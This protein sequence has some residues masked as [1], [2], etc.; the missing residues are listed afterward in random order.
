MYHRQK[1]SL[2]PSAGWS[3]RRLSGNDRRGTST[4]FIASV[5]WLLSSI[6]LIYG[7]YSYCTNNQERV[8]LECT[9]TAC[10]IAKLWQGAIS[11]EQFQREQLLRAEL[12]RLDAEG[13]VVDVSG[14]RQ[15]ELKKLGYSYAVIYRPAV[16]ETPQEAAAE[17]ADAAAPE[18]GA[19]TAEPKP[20]DADANSAA[21]AGSRRANPHERRHAAR[22]KRNFHPDDVADAVEPDAAATVIA[23]APSAPKLP[24]PLPAA[25]TA[26]LGDAEKQAA[27]AAVEADLAAKIKELE[28]L[29]ARSVQAME[30]LVKQQQ[31]EAASGAGAVAAGADD[32]SA[33]TVDAQDHGA[34]L[35]AQA[36][37]AAAAAAE[38]A[39]AAAAAAALKTAMAG[40]IDDAE[41]LSAGANAA[42]EAVLRL[43]KM[44]ELA[45]SLIK[46]AGDAPPPPADAA[47]VDTATLLKRVAELEAQLKA[48]AAAAPANEVPPSRRRLW[49]SPE[50]VNK[51]KESL[52]SLT[53]EHLA[54]K[55]GTLRDAAMAARNAFPSTGALEPERI[56]P[57]EARLVLASWNL[58]RGRAR[59]SRRA[60]ENYV[61]KFEGATEGVTLEERRR[62]STAGIWM[63]VLGVG[64]T[65]CSLIVGNFKMTK[66]RKRN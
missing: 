18:D 22:Q 34:V 64:L 62:W 54:D 60:L 42:A 24:V 14:M 37:S 19:P 39:A 59:A 48:G 56:A 28:V 63:M 27:H 58:G 3:D 29:R 10:R 41:A 57:G 25:A 32:G 35:A 33:V 21:A 16:A 6:G 17:P 7:G 51:L 30:V 61:L 8:T 4:S 2:L 12:V 23:V 65:L 9:A 46:P 55:L 43:E 11:E 13:H 5:C 47:A 50:H 44:K 1:D 38:A 52:E 36:A 26:V 53:G 40:A 49:V 66:S 15:K 31:A 45:D 20:I